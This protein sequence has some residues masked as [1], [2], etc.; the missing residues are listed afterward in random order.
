MTRYAVRLFSGWLPHPDAVHGSDRVVWVDVV[1][2]RTSMTDAVGTS[3]WE[4]D[5]AN[6]VVSDTDAHG[7][8]HTYAYD[9]VGNQVRAALRTVGCSLARST[10]RAWR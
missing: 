4:F 7:H 10:G 6:R 8:T 3:V 1:G 5:W 9:G 2:N